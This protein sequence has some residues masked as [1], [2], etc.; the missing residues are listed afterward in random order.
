M[1]WS[2]LQHSSNMGK[3]WTVR[4]CVRNEGAL[5]NRVLRAEHRGMFSLGSS[6]EAH[7][8]AEIQCYSV[9]H[10]IT[11]C[12]DKLKGELRRNEPLV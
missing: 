6:G 2:E 11:I 4:V 9:I 8:W 10:G 1:L 12:D 3:P 5:G 7:L